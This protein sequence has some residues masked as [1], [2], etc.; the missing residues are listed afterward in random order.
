[1]PHSSCK[2]LN[3][4]PKH[5]QRNPLFFFFFFID[6][7]PARGPVVHPGD[8]QVQSCVP[9]SGIFSH[10]GIAWVPWV[11]PLLPGIRRD[12]NQTKCQ[13]RNHRN[14][15]R[16]SVFGKAMVRVDLR[17]GKG[18]G[19]FGAEPKRSQGP[20]NTEKDPRSDFWPRRKGQTFAKEAVCDEI[21]LPVCCG[22]DGGVR[23]RRQKGVSWR[24]GKPRD[25]RAVP[26]Q[27]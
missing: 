25:T 6:K 15:H 11:T 7:P 27:E 17:P 16:P 22:G 21:F 2:I 23:G 8:T 1:M 18:R 5:N 19:S 26:G 13:L 20:S 10:L 12:P 9:P 14:L 4:S 24:G 3:P